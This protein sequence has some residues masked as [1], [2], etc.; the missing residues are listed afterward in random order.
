MMVGSTRWSFGHD[1]EPRDGIPPL[2]AKG[3]TWTN[4]MGIPRERLRD[5]FEPRILAEW[6]VTSRV[7]ARRALRGG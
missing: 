1:A 6:M 2:E 4:G 7:N 3:L 5:V